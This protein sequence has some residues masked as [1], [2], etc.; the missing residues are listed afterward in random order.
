MDELYSFISVLLLV[1]ISV[2]VRL[3][4][5]YPPTNPHIC[6]AQTFQSM[7]LLQYS[8]LGINHA[9]DVVVL[10]CSGAFTPQH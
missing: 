2:A 4:F 5:L 10:V 8:Y 9:Y 1:N 6:R 7:V 3:S